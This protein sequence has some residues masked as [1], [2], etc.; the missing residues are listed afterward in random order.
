MCKQHT[1][2]RQSTKAFWKQQQQQLQKQQQKAVSTKERNEKKLY[3]I[4]IIIKINEET[5]WA[6]AMQLNGER[7]NRLA[8]EC[9]KIIWTK[10]TTKKNI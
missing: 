2:C 8:I 7:S 3:F 4:N 6:N 9:R 1:F 5:N 10:Q